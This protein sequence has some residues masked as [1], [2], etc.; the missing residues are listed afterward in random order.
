MDGS[1][2]CLQ[3]DKSRRWGWE[4]SR[5]QTTGGELTSASFLSLN[6]VVSADLSMSMCAHHCILHTNI[7]FVSVCVVKS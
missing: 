2:I 5:Y 3:L 1:M 7:Y 6:L 4:G